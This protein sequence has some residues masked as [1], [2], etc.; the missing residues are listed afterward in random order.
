MKQRALTKPAGYS[1]YLNDL[2]L[3]MKGES[4][5]PEEFAADCFLIGFFP[6]L[7]S[8]YPVLRS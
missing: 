2:R 5:K 3:G 6:A 1:A 8:T 4:K 7:G